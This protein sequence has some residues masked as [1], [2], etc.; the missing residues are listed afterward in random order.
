MVGIVDSHACI[1]GLPTQPQLA[2]SPCFTNFVAFHRKLLTD[3][4]DEM[5]MELGTTGSLTRRMPPG[6][7]RPNTVGRL[8][9]SNRVLANPIT[10]TARRQ[11]NRKS[12]YKRQRRSLILVSAPPL[13]DLQSGKKLAMRT[14]L[15]ELFRCSEI[16][17]FKP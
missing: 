3:C 11:Q 12:R 2:S 16:L 9:K 15:Q 10:S 7:C 8:R 1:H 6:V 5:K 13:A 4:R 14:A 17:F